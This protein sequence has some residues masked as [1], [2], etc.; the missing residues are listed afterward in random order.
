MAGSTKDNLW[1][2]SQCQ[3]SIRIQ[4]LSKNSIHIPRRSRVVGSKDAEGM[5]KSNLYH[6]CKDHK[7]NGPGRTAIDALVQTCLAC[8]RVAKLSKISRCPRLNVYFYD[9]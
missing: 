6:D 1:T 2:C 3:L 5:F 7:A 9:T 4:V 8:T